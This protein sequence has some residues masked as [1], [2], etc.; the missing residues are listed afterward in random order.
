M[1]RNNNACINCSEQQ[2]HSRS[3]TLKYACIIVIVIIISSSMNCA[4][5]CGSAAL[6]GSATG[7]MLAVRAAVCNS[8]LGRVCMAVRRA[9]YDSAQ[10]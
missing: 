9:V 3:V 5:V 7:S 2:A 4:K 6:C 8:A 1:L 10:Q